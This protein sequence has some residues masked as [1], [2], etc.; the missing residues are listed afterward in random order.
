MNEG[1]SRHDPWV[2][3]EWKFHPSYKEP[4]HVEYSDPGTHYW[5]YSDLKRVRYARDVAK[6]R[7]AWRVIAGLY[8]DMT[9]ACIHSMTD[10]L[11]KRGKK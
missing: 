11:N 1:Q 3:K 8:L 9:T 7:I 4:W 6:A 10:W 2:P 5:R